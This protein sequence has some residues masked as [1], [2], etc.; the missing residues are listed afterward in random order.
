MATIDT[1]TAQSVATKPAQHLT[2]YDYLLYVVTVLSWSASWFALKLQVGVVPVQ[3]SLL[4]RYAL[5]TAIMLVWALAVRAPMR[6]SLAT[7][8]RFI[9]MGGF[10]FCINFA[11]FY[12]AAPLLASGLLSVV[13]SLASV[14]NVL[15]AIVF[16]GARPSVNVLLGVLMGVVGMA[17]LFWPV[18]AGQNF[19]QSALLGL[20]LC[21]LGTLSF[22][23]GNLFSASLQRKRVPVVSASTWG[24]AYGA[25]LSG[26]IALAQ[27]DAFIFDWS[28]KYVSSLVFLTVVSSVIAFA[29]Y[30]TLLGRIGASRAA[31]ATVMFPV[32]ALLISSVIEDYRM[33]LVAG[34]GLA[35]VLIGNIFV[36]GGSR[37]S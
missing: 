36:L 23:I 19:D 33:G 2:P 1:P 22:C 37:K 25:V 20:G 4:W 32:L 35:I 9:L 30:L 31:Y 17:M 13:F 12:H 28:I 27:G 5:A 29:A 18:I 11:L 10:M 34:I 15:I 8:V 21:I 16:F 14:V 3:V 24:M 7:H 6:F 26:L